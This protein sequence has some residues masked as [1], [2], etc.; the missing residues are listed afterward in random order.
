[1]VVVGEILDDFSEEEGL[2]EIWFTP[3]IDEDR[4]VDDRRS[5]GTGREEFLNILAACIGVMLQAA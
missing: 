4:A 1:M 3:L 2:R 5:I